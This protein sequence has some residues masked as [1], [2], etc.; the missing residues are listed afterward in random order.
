MIIDAQTGW[1]AGVRC[2]PSP[3]RDARP[4]HFSLDLIVVHGISLPPQEFGGHW[5]DLFFTNELPADAHA[6][7]ATIRHLRVSAHALVRRDGS[8]TQ[9][10]PFTE[11]AWHAGESCYC[12][13]YAC[14]DFSVGIE[15]EGADD[16]PYE[17]AQYE[18]LAALV[19]A[20]RSAYPSL[21]SAAIVGHDEIA[22][23]RK[24]DPGPA[25]DWPALR[26]LLEPT[27]PPT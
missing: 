4:P 8:V 17:P 12:G 3:N 18:T 14:N 2:I 7:F 27:V 1:L 11:R 25:F 16:V 23:G 24:T 20:L 9:Y 5:I 13:R 21:R 15:L 19:R 22:P 6:Y 10:V 26:R